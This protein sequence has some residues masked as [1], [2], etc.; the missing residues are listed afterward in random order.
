MHTTAL[1]QFLAHL[2]AGNVFIPEKSHPSIIE[3]V[4][5]IIIEYEKTKLTQ[6]R[7]L[8]KLAHQTC[9]NISVT[10]GEILSP[11]AK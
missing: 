8:T 9:G 1:E 6:K 11:Y 3:F 5:K 10:I 7:T 4:G 2:L